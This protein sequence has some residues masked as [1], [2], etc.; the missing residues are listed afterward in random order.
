MP[1]VCGLKRYYRGMI[2]YQNQDG[3]T[4]LICAA[5][6]GHIDCLRVLLESGADKEVNGRVRGQ[7]FGILRALS[8]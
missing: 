4:A 8:L 7:R 1:R 5:E 6:K 2:G 3:D